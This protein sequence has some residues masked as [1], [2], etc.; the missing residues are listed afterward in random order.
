[1]KLKDIKIK[2]LSKLHTQKAYEIFAKIIPAKNV[3]NG[4]DFNFENLTFDE[5]SVIKRLL[6]KKDNESIL[7][8]IHIFVDVE[9]N[10]LYYFEFV[11]FLKWLNNELTKYQTKE[12]EL[13]VLDAKLIGA[14]IERLNKYGELN[15]KI[16]LG[17]QFGKLPSEIGKMKYLQVLQIMGF[18]SEREII[19][20]NLNK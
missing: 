5:V 16:Q 9:L 6:N 13:S 14:G 4:Q 18:N 7:N 11:A 8:L 10:D 15:T 19:R 12:S 20:Q 2:D 17:E 1:M 3:L